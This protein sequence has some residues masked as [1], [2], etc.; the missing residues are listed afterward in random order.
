MVQASL[1]I[2]HGAWSIEPSGKDQ[3]TYKSPCPLPCS[4]C[5]LCALRSSVV[6]APVDGVLGSGV[7]LAFFEEYAQVRQVSFG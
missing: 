3:A 4:I 2:E 1:G 7:V 6:P 5:S